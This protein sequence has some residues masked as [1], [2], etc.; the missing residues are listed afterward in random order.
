MSETS[1]PLAGQRD[2]SGSAVTQT[3]V[4]STIVWKEVLD[5]T[6]GRRFALGATM[7]LAL[8]VLASIVRVGD[9]RQAH[10]ERNLFL[11]RWLPSVTEQLERD[12]I[13]QVEN[14]RAIS[15]LSIL[16]VGLEPVVPFRFT[17]TKEGLR[18]GQSRSAQNSVDALFGYLDVTFIVSTLLSLL[19]IAF[20]FDSLC[21]ERADGTLALML[22]YPVDRR[23]IVIAK[24]AGNMIVTA[25]CFLPAFTAV[26]VIAA[27]TG[28]GTIAPWHWIAYGTIALLYLLGFTAIGVA[29]SARGGR[30]ADAALT[31]LFIWVMI[32]FLIPR[33][34]ALVVNYVQP[35][36]RAVE[37]GLRE[38]EAISHLRLDYTRRLDSAFHLYM[39]SETASRQDDFNQARKEAIDEL[40][41]RRRDVLARMWDEQMVDEQA[42]EDWLR[43]LSVLSPSAVFQ[44]VAA[45]LSWT[46][47]EQRRHFLREARTYDERIGRRLAESRDLFYSAAH[48]QESAHALVVH[49]DVKPFLIPFQ[50]TWA[51]SAAILS[52]AMLP[53]CMLLLFSAFAIAAADWFIERLDVRA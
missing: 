38:D 20:T 44:Q 36:L 23:T 42:R 50:P 15:P 43:G 5:H 26:A 7:T 40:R 1:T 46:G 10:Q 32:V 31:S 28:V 33:G 17:S 41:K 19:S 37:I 48:G 27:V 13:V 34:V 22:S 21:G 4:F 25:L 30:S 49:D 53:T 9:F 18:F 14:T 52:A 24:I 6:R 51:S 8:F 12:E 35:P 29:V 39:G 2:I 3:H 11:Q 45:E 47:D 16:T